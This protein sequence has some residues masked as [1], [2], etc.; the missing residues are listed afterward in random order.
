VTRTPTASA[1]PTATLPLTAGPIITFFGLTTADNHVLQPLTTDAQGNPV[2]VRPT[3]V[4]FFIV[5]E[6]KMGTSKK[7]PGLKRL[8]SDPNDPTARPDLQILADHNLGNGS[9]AVC[10][11]GPAPNFPI[12]GVP[13]VNPPTFDITSQMVAD[14]LNDFGCRFDD[15]TS[16][17][18]TLSASENP[19]FVASD[20][21][22]QF[23]TAGVVGTEVR[24][25]SGDTLL[26][27]QWRDT[28]GN[29][30]LPRRLVVRAP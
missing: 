13:G 8:N 29:I 12:G 26:T 10:D 7:S 20:T 4:G 1:T 14:A 28:S 30:G 11:V 17:P 9:A 22:T 24:F 19:R 2:Y 23:C 27:V 21:S 18:C 25:P 5:V 16:A 15:N 3:G 6:S